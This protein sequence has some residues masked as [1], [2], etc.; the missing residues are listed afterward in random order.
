MLS[1]QGAWSGELREFEI[2]VEESSGAQI[3][4]S[5][6]LRELEGKSSGS[7]E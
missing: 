1:A 5:G 3:A 6:E 2:L 7:L 4:W